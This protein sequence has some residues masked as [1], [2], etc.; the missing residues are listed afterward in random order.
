MYSQTSYAYLCSISRK[1]WAMKLIFYLQINTN[2]FYK[3]IVLL[4]V[5]MARHAQSTQNNNFIISLQYLKENVK[6][7]VDFSLLI[8]VKRFFKVILSFLMC[9][10][11]HAQITQNK[12]FAISLQYLKKEVN[13]E[14]G[15]LHAGKHENLLQ[16]DTMIL[17]EMVKHFQSSQNS[18][19]TMSVQYLKKKASDKLIFCM[20]I[21]I[22]V[23]YKLISTIWAPNLATRWYYDYWLAWWSILKLLKVTT[24]QIFGIF[25]K[26]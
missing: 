10:A 4:W 11:R 26:S 22:K 23:A 19:F 17:M 18:K 20:Q 3:L 2:I 7:G 13:D 9:V 16:I 21:N 14:V 12:K 6:D 15:F 24:L 1:A 5:C 25:Q 8:I